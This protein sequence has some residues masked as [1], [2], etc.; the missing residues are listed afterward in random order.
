MSL[1]EK[2]LELAESLSTI[3]DVTGYEYRPRVI[4]PGD[5]WPLIARYDFVEGQSVLQATW[6]VFVALPSDERVASD[7]IDRMVCEVPEAL[8]DAVF[9][10]TIEPVT[11]QTSGGDLFA[12]QITAR[13]E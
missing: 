7:W 8:R 10:D 5:A 6:H 4:K 11:I 13:S 2:R 9:V 12:L 3:E 1:P